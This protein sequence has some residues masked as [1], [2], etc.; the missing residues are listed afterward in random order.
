MK[1]IKLIFLILI[2]GL[3]AV[4]NF[5]KTNMMTAAAQQDTLLQYFSLFHEDYKNKNYE[6]A[7]EPGWIVMNTDP[8][9]FVRY[10]LFKKM[11]T[12]HFKLYE[13]ESTSPERKKK[14]ADD[15][16]VVYDKAIQFEKKKEAYYTLR[17][18]YVL[19]KWH[20]ADPTEFIPLYEKAFELDN[21]LPNHYKDILGIVYTQLADDEVN[22]YKVKA[23]EL[24]SKLSE[25]EPDNATWISR[26]ENLAGGDIEQLKDIKKKAWELDKENLEKAWGYASTCMRDKDYEKALEPLNF[27]TTKAP[28]VVNYWKQLAN[29]QQKLNNTDE[30]IQ[31][32]KKLIELQPDNKDSYV[33]IA[34]IYKDLGQ[35]SVAR[36]YLQKAMNLDKEWAYPIYLEA[37]LYEEA[38]RDCSSRNGKLTFMDKC[39]FKLAAETYR[40]AGTKT[41]PYASVGAQRAKAFA[42]TVPT[43]E[44]FFF[45]GYK[46]GAVIKI[47]G[48]CYGWIGRSVKAK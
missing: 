16:L 21:K 41:G 4:N 34:I 6:S 11:E 13:N 24:Y 40:R 37:N 36:S 5:A 25:A 3:F 35:F 7:L 48:S 39:V 31:A 33:N 14:L 26:I 47:E 43:Q 28:T 42:S 9:K 15:I 2:V 8:A 17:K 27:L 44:D 19:Q 1:K 22:D 45:K 10:K 30:A 23:L 46:A 18:A 20:D 32:Y 29:A 12:I 38:A